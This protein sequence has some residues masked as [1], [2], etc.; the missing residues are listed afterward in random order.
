MATVEIDNTIDFT[1]VLPHIEV[2]ATVTPCFT[3][4][5]TV[6]TLRIASFFHETSAFTRLG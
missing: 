3:T 1:Q 6:T 5:V 2:L 4:H